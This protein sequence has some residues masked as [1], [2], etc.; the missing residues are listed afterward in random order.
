MYLVAPSQNLYSVILYLAH[1]LGIYCLMP[2]L[3][4]KWIR[5]LSAQIFSSGEY[6]SDIFLH[7]QIDELPN[8]LQLVICRMILRK[9]QGII[10]EVWKPHDH[11]IEC[12]RHNE[13]IER[14]IVN[15]VGEL[16]GSFF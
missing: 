12:L 3:P 15:G 4:M 2:S 6:I 16:V 1:L 14:H 13:G 8:F 10:S 9:A 7:K 11:C 5:D